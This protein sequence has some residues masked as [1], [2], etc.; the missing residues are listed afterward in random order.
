MVDRG[1][2]LEEPAVRWGPFVMN[3]EDE[4]REALT[5]LRN[6]TFVKTRPVGALVH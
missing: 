5:D 6:G 1:R 2:P 3:T 4:I